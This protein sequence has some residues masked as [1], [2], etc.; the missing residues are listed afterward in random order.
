M[1]GGADAR[2]LQTPSNRQTVHGLS[3][4]SIARSNACS[5]LPSLQAHEEAAA[6]DGRGAKRKEPDA[7]EVEKKEELEGEVEEKEAVFMVSCG[8]GWLAVVACVL[9]VLLIMVGSTT[10]LAVSAALRRV[11]A[12]R[13]LCRVFAE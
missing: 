12:C 3:S 9:E 5:F 6:E 11:K 13:S 7:R 10:W 2:V 4:C 8:A 1:A